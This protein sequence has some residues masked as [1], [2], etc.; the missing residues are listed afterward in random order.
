MG[1]EA[2]EAFWKEVGVTETADLET[3][4]Q[5]FLI[6]THYSEENE[7]WKKEY[8]PIGVWATK[9]YEPQRI[10]DN[11]DDTYEDHIA[12]TV[13]GL[14]IKVAGYTEGNR[15]EDGQRL[16]F[17]GGKGKGKGKGGG[18]KPKATP[19]DVLAQKA[20]VAQQK[21]DERALNKRKK[22]TI[23]RS[24][25]ILKVQP[26]ASQDVMLIQKKRVP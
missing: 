22:A 12:G 21:A 3:V 23:A 26:P 4:V 14:W 5:K 8:Y 9:G 11:C 7:G 15:E 17:G 20:A 6:K 25:K 2:K 10:L 1:K 13:Y 19:E 24:N 16:D 18:S